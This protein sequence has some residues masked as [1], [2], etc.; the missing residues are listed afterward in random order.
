MTPKRLLLIVSLL[1]ITAVLAAC[2]GGAPQPETV[3]VTRTVNEAEPPAA[4]GSESTAGDSP[5]APES[6][7]KVAPTRAPA[8][9]AVAV[10]GAEV[11]SVVEEAEAPALADAA[12]GA[13]AADSPMTTTQNSSLTAGEVDDNA[14][15]DDYL[16]YLRDYNGAQVLKVDVSERQQIWVRDGQERPLA[17]Q[18]VRIFSGDQTIATLRTHSDGRVYFFPRAYPAQ[19]ADYRV[20]VDGADPFTIPAG[21]GQREWFV[22]VV[23]GGQGET[24]V[25]LDVLFLIDATGSMADE[26]Q[27]LKDNIRAISAQVDALPSQPDVRFGLVAYRD[28]EDAFL[29][30]VTDFTPNVETFAAALDQVQADGGGDY[31]ED[32]NQAL[33][34]AIHQ[35]EWRVAN[36]VSLIF[37]VADAP[38]HL[39]Y[40]Q[41]DHYAAEMLQAAQRGIKIYPIASSGL[42]E[43]GEYIFRQLAQATGGRF[44]FLTYGASGPGSTG[45][46]TEFQ[47]SDYTVSALDDLVVKIIEEELAPL[48]R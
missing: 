1:V 45:T 48:S 39:D 14:K 42:D 43:Q 6:G 33:A 20:E 32:L 24:A 11:A 25:N 46:E 21:S 35:P 34:D 38:P 37:L 5:T 19:A 47:V 31:P 9:T 8:P 30:Q 13:S 7:P 41:Q 15:W 26:I 29:T 16:L 27:Q 22:T 3:E 18:Q 4:V 10:V 28:R 17:G 23:N 2:G 12:R 40:G 36:T 44:I